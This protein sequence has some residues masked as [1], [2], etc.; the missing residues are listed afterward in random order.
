M[1]TS[2]SCTAVDPKQFSVH[3]LIWRRV[4]LVQPDMFGSLNGRTGNTMR[5]QI[6]ELTGVDRYPLVH[7]LLL[8]KPAQFERQS[9]DSQGQIA[10]PQK[11]PS[12]IL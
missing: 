3:I 7:L 5:A 1:C 9:A 4:H 11:M 6:L 2:L 12:R 8:I 10:L